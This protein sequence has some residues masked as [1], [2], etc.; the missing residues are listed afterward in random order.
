MSRNQHLEI[1]IPE[2]EITRGWPVSEISSIE[3]CDEA[4]AYLMAACAEIERDL[5]LFELEEVLSYE[6]KV[7]QAN[8][9]AALKYKKAALAIVDRIRGRLLRTERTKEAEE[10]KQQLI[11]F[12]RREVGDEQMG[13]WISMMEK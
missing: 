9:K 1:E 11:N 4:F 7:W 2:I 13:K 12:I 10:Y 8:A 3:E 5:D 6:K